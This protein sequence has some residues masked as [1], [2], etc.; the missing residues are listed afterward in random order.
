[1]PSALMPI[2]I[3]L[4]VD[5]PMNYGR[6]KS[7]SSEC[8]TSLT[9]SVA[10]FPQLFSRRVEIWSRRRRWNDEAG[11]IGV[12]SERVMQPGGKVIKLFFS[13]SPMFK[14]SG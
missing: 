1:M 8:R 12:F 2:A 3:M 6:K 9:F 5:S 4:S 7:Y 11:V 13:S 10:E 14:L